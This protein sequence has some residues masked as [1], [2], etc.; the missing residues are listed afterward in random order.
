M[1]TNS[2]A[3]LCPVMPWLIPG[4]ASRQ[5][6]RTGRRL[7]KAYYDIT[8]DDLTEL[9]GSENERCL[10]K[11][12]DYD[13]DDCDGDDRGLEICPNT[14]HD[15]SRR[16]SHDWNWTRFAQQ[17]LKQSKPPSLKTSKTPKKDTSSKPKTNL[18][19][20]N[21]KEKS[22]SEDDD[23]AILTKTV[24]ILQSR[25][26]SISETGKSCSSDCKSDA[27]TAGAILVEWKLCGASSDKEKDKTTARRAAYDWRR[28]AKKS[29]FDSDTTSV[30]GSERSF[31]DSFESTS[32]S[33]ARWRLKVAQTRVRQLSNESSQSVSCNTQSFESD[34]SET[35]SATSQHT[36]HSAS[37]AAHIWRQR[38]SSHKHEGC[39]EGTCRECTIL[40]SLDVPDDDNNNG[41]NGDVI[42]ELPRDRYTWRHQNGGPPEHN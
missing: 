37:R 15:T 1:G 41:E 40:K 9:S 31:S 24:Q 42:G 18:K 14:P 22:P 17:E 6:R 13:N 12:R 16:G 20:E 7:T 38:S 25:N 2:S 36:T 8:T 27:D 35:E 33:A 32:R 39:E 21:T 26:P 28:K 23:I 19:V 11:Y 34:R 4:F 29:S 10:H 30:S 3:L 5:K